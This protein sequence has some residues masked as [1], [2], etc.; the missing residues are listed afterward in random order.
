MKIFKAPTKIQSFQIKQNISSIPILLQTFL[1]WVLI[2]PHERNKPNHC[3]PK[4]E[5]LMTVITQLVVQSV[6]TP[7][8]ANYQLNNEN[9]K[10]YNNIETPL[11]VGLGLYIYHSTR[12]KKLVKFLSDLNLSIT[13]DKVIDIKK[14]IVTS[15]MK[16]SAENDGVF[17]PSS[18]SKN[19]PVFFAIDN[20]DLKIDTVD[21]K[22]QLHGTAIAV[23]QQQEYN[24]AKVCNCTLCL[25]Y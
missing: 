15:I 8:Q 5:S 17:V 6:K 3:T 11:N 12:S 10:T 9:S 1:K 25:R 20:T 4:I 16:K 7:K 14:G 2:G 23:Y 13:Y 19:V 18:L 22:S 21:G 24:Q